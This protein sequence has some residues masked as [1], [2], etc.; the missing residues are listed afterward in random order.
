[1]INVKKYFKENEFQSLS[2]VIIAWMVM[3]MLSYILLLVDVEI[4]FLTLSLGVG[5]VG[6]YGKMTA[7]LKNRFKGFAVLDN[8]CVIPILSD[9]I[10]GTGM[11]R[12]V[13]SVSRRL[14][15]AWMIWKCAG[16]IL[17]I[18]AA[19]S[20]YGLFTVNIRYG[21]INSDLGCGQIDWGDF[22]V[23]ATQLCIAFLAFWVFRIIQ[24]VLTLIT[25]KVMKKQ[26]GECVVESEDET[27]PTGE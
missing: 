9:L 27:D 4:Y 5:C 26:E 15:R 10:F 24:A 7:S 14:K 13:Q 19:Y 1:M 21:G 17:G 20:I 11:E 2:Y 3:D 22:D 25:A 23:K 18:F 12:V 8:L 16:V 6:L